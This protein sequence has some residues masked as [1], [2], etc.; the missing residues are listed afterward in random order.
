[1]GLL[2][3]LLPGIGGAI[4]GLAGNASNS[5]D[6]FVGDNGLVTNPTGAWDNF[7]NGKTNDVNKEIAE[8]NL[9]YQRERNAIEDARYVNETTYNRRFAKEEQAYN[10]AF[11]E[12]ER[13]YQRAFAEDEREYQRQFAENEREYQRN[14]QNELFN[15]EDTALERQ[16]SSLSSMGINPLS[17]QLNGLGAGQ[18]LTPSSAGGSSAPSSSSPSAAAPSMSNRGGSALHNDFQM[19]DTG[20]LGALTPLMSLFQGVSD[21]STGNLTRDSLRAQ[22][23]YQRLINQSQQIENAQ[24]EIELQS[25][26]E[27]IQADTASKKANTKTTDAIRDFEIKDKK[28]TAERNQRENL[29]QEQ[30]GSHDLMNSSARLVTD[31]AKISGADSL[32]DFEHSSANK[33]KNYVLDS[34]E[35]AYNSVSKALSNTIGKGASAVFNYFRKPKKAKSSSEWKRAQDR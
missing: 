3:F 17:Q 25:K 7:K 26:L 30:Y 12:N 2:S 21:L 24:K 14:L 10:R 33:A 28:A 35:T 6:P 18:A 19:Q 1:M 23:D 4:E 32:D 29:H 11:A 27:N 34:L 20:I 13:D 15:R 9:A 31:L 8:E 22:N 5:N 16:A